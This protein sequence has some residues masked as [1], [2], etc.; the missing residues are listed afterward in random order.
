[1]QQ[2]PELFPCVVLSKGLECVE[3]LFLLRGFTRVGGGVS[4]PGGIGGDG[5]SGGSHYETECDLVRRLAAAVTGKTKGKRWGG[6]RDDDFGGKGTTRA[7]ILPARATFY[8]TFCGTFIGQSYPSP[9]I[10]FS[11]CTMQQQNQHDRQNCR[12]DNIDATNSP[13]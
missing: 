4:G 7:I 8:L 12:N 10:Q 13:G 9:L 2:H 5:G 11:Q 6:R 3:Q 1:M